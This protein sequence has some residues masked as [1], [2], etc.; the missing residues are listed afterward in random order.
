MQTVI[1]LAALTSAI[2]P[3]NRTSMEQRAP[4]WSRG[5]SLILS[6]IPI[7]LAYRWSSTQPQWSRR[8]RATLSV[9][10]LCAYAYRRRSTP[11]HWSRLTVQA[12][13]IVMAMLAQ[14]YPARRPLLAL[15]GLSLG[16]WEFVLQRRRLGLSRRYN[17]VEGGF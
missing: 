5:V 11:A 10:T 9:L 16:T 2:W 3:R 15:V 6:L 14:R 13:T 8:A 7:V 1:A 4:H 12:L 17:R